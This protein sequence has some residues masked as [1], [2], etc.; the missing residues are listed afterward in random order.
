[1]FGNILLKILEHCRVLRLPTTSTMHRR[2]KAR[3]LKRF[4]PMQALANSTKTKRCTSKL[5]SP[6]SSVWNEAETVVMWETSFRKRRCTDRYKHLMWIDFA[7]AVCSI[8]KLPFYSHEED[9]LQPFLLENLCPNGEFCFI[10]LHLSFCR[11]RR[12]LFTTMSSSYFW[13]AL[14]PESGIGEIMNASN[15]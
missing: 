6:S 3:L 7:F 9:K 2:W 11:S 13:A 14:L 5:N 15:P 4:Q 12:L 8:A 10:F 1:M